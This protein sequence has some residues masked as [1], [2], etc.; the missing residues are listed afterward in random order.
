MQQPPG[1]NA[2]PRSPTDRADGGV[3]PGAPAPQPPRLAL[4]AQYIRDLSFEN[5][6]G[7]LGPGDADNKPQVDVNVNVETRRVA[8]NR[9][10]SSLKINAKAKQQ[11]NVAFVLE[12]DYC[13]VFDV[14]GFPEQ[15]LAQILLVECPR[16]LFPF[17]RR[18]AA[19]AVRDGGFPALFLDPIDFLSLYRQRLQQEAAK[20]R[21]NLPPKT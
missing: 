16:L 21:P 7:P 18:I 11:E 6:H 20:A 15:L 12:L 1:E 17:A 2:P 3:D 8:D 9:Y 13:G 14:S 10:E 5:P 19:D 4:H